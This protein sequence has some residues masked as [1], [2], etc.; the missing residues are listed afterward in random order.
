MQFEW[1]T[2]KAEVNLQKHGIAFIDA[3]GIFYDPNR[4]EDD[5]SKPEH[6]EIRI[7]TIGIIQETVRKQLIIAVI[8]T[9]RNQ[10][11]RIISARRARKN[12]QKRYY[13]C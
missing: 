7:K 8:S 9:K 6:G 2:K 10:N 13:N 4:I 5:S 12:E 3:I 11:I 1:D